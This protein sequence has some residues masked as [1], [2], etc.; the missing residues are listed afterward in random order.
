MGELGLGGQEHFRKCTQQKWSNSRSQGSTKQGG[1]YFKHRWHLQ[2]YVAPLSLLPRTEL[3]P[4]IRFWVFTPLSEDNQV[5]GFQNAD[6]FWFAL[7]PKRLEGMGGA[8]EVIPAFIGWW[9]SGMG[10]TVGASAFQFGPQSYG[11]S[12]LAYHKGA[13]GSSFL[14]VG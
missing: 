7:V 11:I 4:Q 6:V 1:L 10:G 5:L 9:V 12:S 3:Y 8:G 13:L 14:T 2:L